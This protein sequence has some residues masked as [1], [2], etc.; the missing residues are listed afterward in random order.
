[1]P[2]VSS[3]KIEPLASSAVEQ[4]DL[5]ITVSEPAKAGF[6]NILV[7]CYTNKQEENSL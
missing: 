3:F 2:I 5:N 4:A 1:M 7:A 6:L